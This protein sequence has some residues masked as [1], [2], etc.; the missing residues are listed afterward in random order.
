MEGME[1]R[2]FR[3]AEME[4]LVRADDAALLTDA[5]RPW[6]GYVSSGAEPDIVVE[7]RA[8]PSFAAPPLPDDLQAPGFAVEGK[9]EGRTDFARADCAGE[10][11]HDG[12]TVVARFAGQPRPVVVEA[13]VRI[14]FALA[15]P[16]RDGLLLHSSGAAFGERGLLFLGPS[17]AGKST[18][19]RLLRA[20]EPA[21]VS[22]GDELIIARRHGRGF[23]AYATPFAGENGPAAF[24]QAPLAGLCFL[25]Q[26]AAHRARPIPR[27][28]ALR[29]LLRNVVAFVTT[30][31]Q[32]A[33]TLD[34]AADL[35][36]CVTAHI[37]EF[38]KQSDVADVLPGL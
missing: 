6:S 18:I 12:G 21:P 36:G 32:A 1:E 31:A 22:L 20:R 11:V 35:V 30:P 19:E 13:A 16:R 3:L 4:V 15:L 25:A 38:S 14:A 17:G 2:R 29:R 10:V 8:S 27:A 7:V 24:A 33:R 5:A 28:D 23:R 26:A 9:G 34:C 37:L